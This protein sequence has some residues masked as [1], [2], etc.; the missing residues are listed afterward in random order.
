MMG[1]QLFYLIV[2]H[3]LI[4]ESHNSGRYTRRRQIRDERQGDRKV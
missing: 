4:S 1:L 2:V 3:G